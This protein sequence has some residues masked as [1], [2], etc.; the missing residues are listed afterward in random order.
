MNLKEWARAIDAALA[1]LRAKAG[2]DPIS[3]LSPYGS[4][5]LGPSASPAGAPRHLL[6][7]HTPSSAAAPHTRDAP[8][9]GCRLPARAGEDGGVG[10]QEKTGRGQGSQQEQVRRRRR[11][12][13]A[14][15][16]P[17]TW[18]LSAH[19]TRA[20][21]QAGVDGGDVHRG[22]RHRRPRGGPRQVADRSSVQVRAA[23]TRPHAHPFPTST[24]PLAQPASPSPAVQEPA[25][26]ALRAPRRAGLEGAATQRGEGAR[27]HHTATTAPIAPSRHLPHASE[28]T[29]T[30]PHHHHHPPLR[31]SHRRW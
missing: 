22:R 12:R 29:P 2:L 31:R 9:L 18:T 3:C 21:T 16:P 4:P 7:P 11:R 10:Q 19:Q 13:H 27:R 1:E 20:D 14:L 24:P 25:Q 30:H 15:R 17:C 5:K 8:T 28:L 6:T 26:L 23:R